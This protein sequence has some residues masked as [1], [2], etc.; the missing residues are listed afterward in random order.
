MWTDE[1]RLLA[2][3]AQLLPRSYVDISVTERSLTD[4]IRLSQN[5]R[6][7]R[8]AGQPQTRLGGLSAICAPVTLSP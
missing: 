2:A 8:P 4:E 7:Y 3:G 5:R 1:I 6:A